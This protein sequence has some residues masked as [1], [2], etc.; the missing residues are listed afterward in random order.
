[1]TNTFD[2]R[3]YLLSQV[4]ANHSN[5]QDSSS[6]QR[7][8]SISSSFLKSFMQYETS[9]KGIHDWTPIDFKYISITKWRAFSDALEDYKSEK[10]I[11]SF[12]SEK[13]KLKAANIGV[14]LHSIRYSFQNVC[15]FNKPTN[16]NRKTKSWLST[17]PKPKC[18]CYCYIRLWSLI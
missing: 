15:E 3:K 7:A 10:S 18:K 13:L 17:P 1:M 6:R 16:Q 12:K 11:D 4:T 5:Y 14:K 9:Q 2:T 8:K